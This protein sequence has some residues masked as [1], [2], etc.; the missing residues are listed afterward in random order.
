[1]KFCHVQAL[2]FDELESFY[3]W[4]TW[5]FWLKR[6]CITLKLHIGRCRTKA[7]NDKN[8]SKV[9]TAKCHCNFKR[10]QKML[11][12][13]YD[14]FSLV[15]KHSALVK[16]AYIIESVSLGSNYSGIHCFLQDGNVT[17]L[18]TKTPLEHRRLIY[19]LRNFK[20]NRV[21]PKPQN[22]HANIHAISIPVSKQKCLFIAVDF[23]HLLFINVPRID[24]ML[25]NQPAIF[26]LIFR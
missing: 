6:I 14:I 11:L 20:N 7:W 8:E 12:M 22:F 21:L 24:A 13:T 1:M 10:G 19:D 5:T 3:N 2:E 23:R 9:T 17:N 16:S 15:L 4:L 18:K 25:K 26:R